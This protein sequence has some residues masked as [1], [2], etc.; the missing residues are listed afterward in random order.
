[1]WHRFF[2][3]ISATPREGNFQYID[4]VSDKLWPHGPNLLDGA[5]TKGM[6]GLDATSGTVEWRAL[7]VETDQIVRLPVLRNEAPGQVASISIRIPVRGDARVGLNPGE[8]YLVSLLARPADLSPDSFYFV[9]LYED[10]ANTFSELINDRK[11]A[12]VTYLH[13]KGFLRLGKYGV[14][15][16]AG[17]QDHV[18][19]E[20]GLSGAG[21]LAIWD[22]KFLSVSAIEAAYRGRRMIS[23][24]DFAGLPVSERVGLIVKPDNMWSLSG[25]KFLVMGYIPVSDWAQTAIAWS[26]PIALLLLGLFAVAVMMRRQWAY[27]ERFPFPMARIPCA[28]IGDPEEDEHS[29]WSVIWRSRIMWTGFALAFIWGLLRAWAFYNPKVPDTTINI[30][31]NQYLSDA[32][33]GGAWNIRFSISAVLVSICIFIELNVLLSFVVGFLLFRAL[34]WVGEFSGLNVNAG[35]PYQYQQTVGA[36][37]GYAAVV[38]FFTRKYLW[39]V[40]TAACRRGGG[41]RDA[42]SPMS[43]RTALLMLVLVH[44]GIVIWA[45]WLG[46]QVWGVLAY[47]CFLM[48]IG[49]VA[50][51]LRCECGLPSGY[52]TPYNAMLFVSLLGGM[53][54]FGPAGLMVCLIASGFLTVSVFFYIP[55]VQLELIEFGRRYRVNPRHVTIAVL[56]GLAGGLFIGGWVFLSNSYAVGGNAIRSQWS[57]NQGWFFTAYKTQL[58]QTT[59]E[60]LRAQAGETAAKGLPPD[61]WGYLFGGGIAVV[62]A[63]L[64]Q[65]FAGFWFHPIGFV[66]GSA[67]MLSW[68][69]G[70]ALTAWVIR[71]IVLKVGGAATVKTKLFP[72]FIGVFLGSAVFLLLNISYAG[73]RQSIGVEHIYCVMP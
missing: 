3:I 59:G 73:Y 16:S 43:N 47:F 52:F 24:K 70:S 7:E 18:R 11:A 54:V 51:K 32:G 63:V 72:F 12:E 38:I 57:Y 9:R 2:G 39:G 5:F 48:V 23:Q 20:M 28:L 60:F 33:W 25:V 15:V 34:Y 50:T 67:F 62:L 1:M 61:T 71:S 55:G 44:V 45:A 26:T 19:L 10:G 6:A 4:A 42:D 29:V 31:L 64:R 41:V 30:H 56:M 69:W 58:A 49:F 22:P 37:L 65:L 66:L 17:G 53:T 40:V 46:V 36:Y 8:P 68:T 27:S 13:Q 35:Y 21:E 14:D